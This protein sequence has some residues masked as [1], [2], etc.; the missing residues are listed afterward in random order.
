MEQPGE[1]MPR[2]VIFVIRCYRRWGYFVADYD[3]QAM[4]LCLLTSLIGL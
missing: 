3:W 1:P 4:G 2:F